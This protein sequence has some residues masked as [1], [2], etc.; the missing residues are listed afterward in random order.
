MKIYRWHESWNFVVEDVGY[1]VSGVNLVGE[2]VVLDWHDDTVELGSEGDLAE[3]KV[4]SGGSGEGD[5]RVA[6]FGRLLWDN[7]GLKLE[8]ITGG[9]ALLK[10]PGE[11]GGE[12]EH[13]DESDD[14]FH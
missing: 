4:V 11:G 7:Q 3:L 13:G 6:W 5:L 14:G 10:G 12:G 9:S 8:D 1:G 2:G